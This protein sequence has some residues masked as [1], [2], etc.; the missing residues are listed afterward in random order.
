MK[1]TTKNRRKTM[2]K[3]IL[4]GR[5]TAKPELRYTNSNIAFTNF[6]LAVNRPPKED[7]TKEADFIQIRVWKK[8]AENVCKYLDKGRLV[9]IEGRIQTDNYTNKDGERKYITV[10]V[11]EKIEFLGGNK[12]EE[13]KEEVPEI[14]KDP[15]AD[16]GESV[17]IDDNFLD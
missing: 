15:F 5:L 10:V 11:C 3:V 2:N 13:S 4:I 8:Q 1:D 7:G 6:S 9:S 17:S 14:E 16:F 12:K